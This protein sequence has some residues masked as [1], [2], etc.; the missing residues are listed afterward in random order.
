LSDSRFS[1]DF[2]VFFLMN[3]APESIRI[4]CAG[5]NQTLFVPANSVRTSWVCDCVAE[6]K[7]TPPSEGNRP[8]EFLNDEHKFIVVP[9]RAQNPWYA[10][11]IGK[12]QSDVGIFRGIEELCRRVQGF[13]PAKFKKFS[14]CARARRWLA[15]QVKE[16][17]REREHCERDPNGVL[18]PPDSPSFTESSSDDSFPRIATEADQIYGRLYRTQIRLRNKLI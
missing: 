9:A 5:C 1:F 7:A 2:L 14:T 4:F 17:N 18:A 16:Q 12:K 8:A 3:T 6:A 10:V 15:R 11:A 13:R